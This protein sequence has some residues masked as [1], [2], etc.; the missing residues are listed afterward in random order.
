MFGVVAANW[1]SLNTVE[2]MVVSGEM[3]SDLF[4]TTLEIR[5][6]EKNYFLY[7]QD[8]DYEELLFYVNKAENLLEKNSKEFG[9]FAT[10]EV[11]HN[12]RDNIKDYKQLLE[13]DRIPQGEIAKW[14]WEEAVRKKGKTIVTIAESISKTERRVMQTTLRSAK[15][16]LLISVA[17]LVFTGF[18][19]GAIYYRMFAKPL[20]M[21][22]KH[23]KRIADGEFSLMPIKYRDREFVSLNNAFNRMILELDARQRHLVQSEK[24]ASLGTLLFGVAHE[25]NN[26]LSNIS[27]SCEI[28]KE[29]IETADLEYKKELLSQI[30]KDTDRARDVVRS[31]LEFSK[32]GEKSPFFLKKAVNETIRFIKG[33]VPTKVSITLDIPEDLTL[34]ADKQKIQQMLLNLIK[35]SIEAIPHEGEI[36]ITARKIKDNMV[37]L[38]VTDTGVGIETEVID[39]IFDPFFSSKKHKKGYGL[40]LFI[41]H[42]IV[43]EHGGSITVDSQPGRGTTFLIKLP[44]KES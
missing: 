3:V 44:L 26:P 5:R 28:L 15:K 17:F 4:D 7:E 10:P 19:V 20:W 27:T 14:K 11:I 40:G 34:F 39:Q 35:N 30:E 33:E 16:T 13:A 29:E 37:E 42:N 25:L 18:V 32:T 1:K 41:V 31:L 2:D 38:R 9:L 22:E 36:S 43:E 6:F 21:L 23:M 8:E 12:L 24:L